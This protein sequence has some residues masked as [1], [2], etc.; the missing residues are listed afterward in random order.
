LLIEA[1]NLTIAASTSAFVTDAV[2]DLI[3]NGTVTAA[4]AVLPVFAAE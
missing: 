3:A 2:A 1:I 4:I